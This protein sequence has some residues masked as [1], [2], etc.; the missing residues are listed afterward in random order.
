MRRTRVEEACSERNFRAWSRRAF[1][2]AEK[3]KFTAGGSYGIRGRG[4]SRGAL[5]RACARRPRPGD[6][7]PRLETPHP[8]LSP[9]GERDTEATMQA[10][11]A[12]LYET[13]KPVVVEDVEVLEP[14]SHEVAVRWAANGGCHSD[15]H[16]VTGVYP[17]LL[18]VNY[19]HE[20]AGGRDTLVSGEK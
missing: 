9:R 17:Q 1:W 4:A 8:A 15:L 6:Y 13:K 2:S 19:W 14:G 5:L 3:S 12:V 11:A 18:P 16:V 20:A 10:T 7:A